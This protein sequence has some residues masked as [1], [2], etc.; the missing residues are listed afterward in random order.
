MAGAALP[1]MIAEKSRRLMS[2]DALKGFDMF[3]ILM[4]T[5]PIFHALL[6]AMGF[7]GCWLDMQMDHRPWN[8]FTFYDTIYP[9]FLF[10]S[11]VSFSYSAAS[12]RRRGLSGARIMLGLLRRA[13]VL[14]LLG[15]T[16]F[17]SLRFDPGTFTLFS[18]IG[19]IGISCGIAGCI[20]VLLPRFG[21]RLGVLAAILVVYAALPFFVPCPGA[22]EGVLPYASPKSCLYSWMDGNVFPRPLFKAGFAGVFSMVAT[23]ISG[24]LAGDWLR[25]DS[26]SGTRR[27]A[28]L[29]A[30]AAVA[31]A[32]GLVFAF[33]LGRYSVP[34]NKPI[35]SSSYVLVSAA[36]SL[37]MLAL[38]YWII[39]VKGWRRWSFPFRV[40]GMNVLFAYLASRTVFPFE[41]EK[42]FLFGG[43]MRLMPTPEWG[44]F[45]GQLGYLAVDWLVMY[46][47]YRRNWF[48]KA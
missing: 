34:I 6:A 30:S 38:F 32:V 14:V 10:M 17:G 12:S 9:L 25:N 21:Q 27:T 11:G 45:A 16:I 46:A 1:Q 29:L 15:S 7:G 39:D 33:G 35:W 26:L 24:V 5:Y 22:P 18:V 23:A 42:D 8:G 4:P 19:R 36:Y 47:L 48:F 3:W 31:L 44:E 13:V 28:G 40:V 2:L 37:G 43:V 20:C 41:W